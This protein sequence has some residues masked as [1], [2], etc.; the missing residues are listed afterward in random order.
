MT[1]GHAKVSPQRTMGSLMKDDRGKERYLPLLLG[2]VIALTVLLYWLSNLTSGPEHG[3]RYDIPAI[4]SG[5][6]FAFLVSAIGAFFVALANLDRLGKW[7][8]SRRSGRS[9]SGDGPRR[10]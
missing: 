1:L 9:V 3:G 5:A 10:G 4:H 8:E 6:W 7:V 2:G